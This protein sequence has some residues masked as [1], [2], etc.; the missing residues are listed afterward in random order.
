M[1]KYITLAAAGLFLLSL[2]PARAQ[3]QVEPPAIPPMLEGQ[4]PLAQPEMPSTPKQ[5]EAQ[6]SKSK[7]KTQ[8]KARTKTRTHK[9][10]SKKAAVKKKGHSKSP[11]A[12]KKKGQKSNNHKKKQEQTGVKRHRSHVVS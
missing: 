8:T 12:V 4:R 11:K 10:A 9:Q 2:Q 6:K 5:P 7:A 1:K 3:R